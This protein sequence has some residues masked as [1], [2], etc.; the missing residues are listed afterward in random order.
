MKESNTDEVL[1]AVIHIATF[2][3]IFIAMYFVGTS[4]VPE[5]LILVTPILTGM[6]ACIFTKNMKAVMAW[7]LLGL[8]AGVGFYF[9]I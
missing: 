7:A 6:A 2:V 3:V 1:K 8:A 4:K 5:L 9:A